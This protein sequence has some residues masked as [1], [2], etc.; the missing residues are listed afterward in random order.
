SY[1]GES[2]NFVYGEPL[3]VTDVDVGPDGNVYFALGGRN[4]SGGLYRVVYNGANAMQRPAANTPLDRVLT[5]PMPRS[6][7]SR[8]AAVDAREEMGAAVWQQSLTAEARNAQASPERR[9]RAL[10][11]LQVF[12]PG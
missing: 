7:F 11:L 8:Q 10:E 4:T 5:M 6:A 3:N 1:S 2:S 12:G 9:V